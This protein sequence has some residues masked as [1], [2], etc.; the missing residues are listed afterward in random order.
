MIGITLSICFNQAMAQDIIVSNT[1]DSGAGSLRQAIIDAE[2]N[3]GPDVIDM[4]GINGTITLASGLPNITEDLT[5]NGAGS[6]MTIIDGAGQFRPFF[7]GGAGV[8]DTEAP[9]VVMID[10][11]VHNGFAEGEDAKWICWR[12]SRYGWRHVHQ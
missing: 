11:A 4:T 5:I 1:D 10:L 2:A 6:S 12:W 3:A 9:I 7:I 8:D